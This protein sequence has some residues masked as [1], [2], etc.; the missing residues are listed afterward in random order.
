LVGIPKQ[1]Y[2]RGSLLVGKTTQEMEKNMK[3]GNK[4]AVARD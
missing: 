1:H 4:G 2:N 3:V